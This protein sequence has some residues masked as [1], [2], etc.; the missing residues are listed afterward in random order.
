M[1]YPPAIDEIR[2]YS[3]EMIQEEIYYTAIEL[4]IHYDVD[5][6]AYYKMLKQVK[7]E[8]TKS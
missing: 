3:N 8:R 1:N 5:D 7:A 2:T 6:E 4:E